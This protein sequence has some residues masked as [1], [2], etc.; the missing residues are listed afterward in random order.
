MTT[1]T[2]P[3][4]KPRDRV[5][6]AA[7]R[8]FI[9]E[10]VHAV[11]VDRLA[12]E[13]QVSKR[14]IYQHFESKDA[15]VADMLTEYGP[16]VVAGYFSQGDDGRTPRERALHVYDALHRAAEA[17]D[18]FGCPFVNVATEL[19][20]R[21][22][23]AALVAQHFKGELTAYF[24]RQAEAASAASPHVLAVQLT[25]LF[26]GASASAAL[27]GGTPLA[28]RLAAETLWD[29]AVSAGP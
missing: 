13:A 23:P 21:E 18:Y 5:L 24:Q 28:A 15:I 7:A 20:D 25:L 17:G 26:D 27:C 11:G 8:L 3:R 29:A 6:D 9:R 16:R 14:S 12:Q 22:H 10:G 1:T 2:A 4:P 19:R